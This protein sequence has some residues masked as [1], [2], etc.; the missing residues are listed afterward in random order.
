M[1][2]P[3]KFPR[4]FGVLTL[5]M[6][7]C[8][9][10]MCCPSQAFSQSTSKL[11]DAV[12]RKN[13]DQIRTLIGQKCDVNAAQP[14]GTTALHW[15]VHLDDLETTRILIAAG[16]NVDAKNHYGVMP[17]SLACTNGNA[18][19]VSLLLDSGADPNEKLPGGETILMTAARTGKLAPVRTLLKAGVDVNAREIKKQTAI[20]WAAAEGHASVVKTLIDAGADY[21]TPLKSGF[22]PLFFAVRDGHIDVV[23][24]LLD[25]GIDVNET[26][27][28]DAKRGRGPSPGM[29]PLSLAV[30]NGHFELAV[31]LL[32][33]GADPND[34]RSGFTPLH[35]MVWVRKPD[36][37]DGLDG[38]P[39]PEGS[40]NIDSLQFVKK[41]VE[42]GADV[43]LRLQRSEKGFGRLNKKQATAFLMACK[44]ADLPLMKL[45]LELKADPTIPNADQTTPLMVAAGIAT[46]AREKRQEPNRK[47]SKRFDCCSNWERKSTRLIT[48][49]KRRCTAPPTKAFRKSRG[50]STPTGRT[51]MSGT[52][53]TAKA[54]RRC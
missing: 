6:L 24:L 23:K 51:S 33:S 50:S 48:R 15:S 7:F 11:A 4:L 54:G 13:T 42:H 36:R 3:S 41:L 53:K 30:E 49:E 25:R 26:M 40:G 8:S 34:Q 47:R 43:N 37:G 32:E 9:S 14:D 16:A 27:S 31:F 35:R 52:R 2:T 44:T 1:A 38:S 20:M 45:L 10:M 5:L 12:E 18:A 22:T 28:V 21:K 46:F 29:S 39:P 17:L 19:I